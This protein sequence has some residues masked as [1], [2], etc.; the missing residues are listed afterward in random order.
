VA[1]GVPSARKAELR[2]S[3]YGACSANSG[4]VGFSQRIEA[5]R[6]HRVAAPAERRAGHVGGL[7][8]RVVH[9]VLHRHGEGRGVRAEDAS[10]RVDHEASGE[11][12]CGAEAL[13]GD[14]VTTR[15]PDALPGE[16]RGGRR[17]ARDIVEAETPP[18]CPRSRSPPAARVAASAGALDIGATDGLRGDLVFKGGEPVRVARRHG[19]HRRAPE[20]RRAHVSSRRVGQHARRLRVAALTLLVRHEA[21]LRRGAVRGQRR[22]GG[23][24]RSV[25]RDHVLRDGYVS[26]CG[27]VLPDGD[28]LPNGNVLPDGNVLPNGNVLHDSHVLPDRDVLPDRHVRGRRPPVASRASAQ[29]HQPPRSASR[30]HWDSPERRTASPVTIPPA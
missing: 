23:H 7:R 17:P 13:R 10:A 4:P 24:G 14:L 18:R 21:P 1:P 29:G 6:D 30:S 2:H 16:V 28:V 3:R 15:A 9:R 20:P 22:E 26:H 25:R 11:A 8:R 19:H 5:A 27:D 12:A